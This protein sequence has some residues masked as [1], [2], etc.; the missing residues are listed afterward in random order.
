MKRTSIKPLAFLC[1]NFW[2]IP[3]LAATQIT[4]AVLT[5]EYSFNDT[6]TSTNAVDSVGGANGALYPGAT[7]PGDGTVALDGASGFVYL[8]DDIVSNYTSVSF[9]IWT[10]PTVNPT[11]ARLFDFGTNQ[12]GKGTGGAGGTGG[13]GLTWLYLCLND[14]VS[15][16]FR[17]DLNPGGAMT[18]PQPAA[19]QLHHLVFTIDAT[20]QTGSLY[21]NGQLVG[22]AKPFT[23]TPQGVGHTFND[24]IGRSQFPD[25]Y[26]NG[27]IDEFRIYNNAVTPVQVEADYEAGPNSTTGTPGA[28]SGIQFSNSATAIVGG[29]FSPNLIGTYASLTNNVNISTM[30]GIT[31]S[32]D[33][34]NIVN[35]GTDG[36][37][38]A[39]AAGSTTI[40]ASY[41]SK[42]AALAVTVNLEPAVIVHRYGFNEAAGTTTIT[43]S[44]GGANGTLVNGTGTAALDGN[45]K[46]TLDG[47]AS[48]AYVSLPS[49]LMGKLTNATFQVWVQNQD[50]FS[51]WAEL[52]AFGTN[53]GSQGLNYITLIPN[54]PAS[55]KLRLDFHGSTD[56]SFDAPSALPTSNEVCV[57]VTYN[58]SAQSA[59]IYVAGRK[60][61]S[62]PM[63]LPLYGIPDG[64]NYI[65]QSEWYGSGDPYFNGVLN[66]FRIYSGVESD[67]QIAIDAV[68]GPNTIITNAGSLLSLTVS[69]PD[70]NVDVHGLSVPIKVLANFANVS[71]VD[72]TTLSQTSLSNS[73]ASVGK[74]T[75][76]NFLPMNAG[77]STVTA[78]Y[79]GV[80]GS[81]IMNVVDTNAWPTLLH[82]Y[83][84]NETSGTT[85]NDSVGTI[86]GTIN[87]PV[88]LTG[89]QMITPAG[90]PPP[91]G[92]G[93]PTASSGWVSF[94]PGQGIVSGLPNEASIECWTVWQGGGVWQEMFDFGA[95]AT[96]GVSLG[97]GT[98]VMVSPHDGATGSLRLEWFPGGLVL[99]GPSLQAGVLSQVVITH[100]QDRQLDKLYLNGQLISSGAN[101]ALWSSLPD[102]DNWLARDQ[103]PDPMFNGAYS[104]MRIWNGA[105]TAGQV[106]NLY[107]AG[108]NVVVGPGLQVSAANSQLTLKWQVNTTGFVLQSSTNLVSGTW[109]AV[110]GGT[111]TVVN[112]F[113]NLT[114]PLPT[115]QTFFRLKQ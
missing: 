23:A 41:Q 106:A 48:S 73:D 47:N 24:Y 52:W 49:G 59:S 105:L 6:I 36:N 29:K 107:A 56:T 30:S 11:W 25:P 108:P 18:A 35:F 2:V 14:G 88:T 115:V 74:I 10:T 96:P 79:N 93:M 57:T 46:L 7:L 98:Y 62:N 40:H 8:P 76:G 12:G 51:D 21:D 90:N 67:L 16:S 44:V 85:L 1:K 38:H 114:L 3:L 5:H 80:S 104:D 75:S 60:L 99:T 45:G 77:V 22:F 26:Y 94:P 69:T 4:R 53:N 17:A 103:W 72:V 13:N 70:T 86:N 54:N 92:S 9:E 58:Y 63:T 19:G 27:S 68:T 37:F 101:A 109:A 100:D 31:Y 39:V 78:T 111:Q 33:N 84:F 65:G 83:N 89:Q 95:A 32:S 50:L 82:R 64:D 87:G 15:G 81:V 91:D 97:G 61:A 55:H 43:D 110:T 42:S 34:T 20:A 102:T 66:E 28:L 71:G 113:N 112:G